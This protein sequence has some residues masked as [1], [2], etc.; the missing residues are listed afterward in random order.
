MGYTHVVRVLRAA[1][2]AVVAAALPM[3]YACTIV[4]RLSLPPADAGPDASDAGDAGEAAPDAFDGC[5][6]ARFPPRPRIPD[7]DAT[8]E[9][10]VAVRSI[11]VDG[12]TI[13]YDLD[14][15][16]T[17]APHDPTCTSQISTCDGDGGVDDQAGLAMVKLGL[18][19]PF[20]AQMNDAIIGAGR[21]GVVI[22]VEKYNGKSEDANVKVSIYSSQGPATVTD[23]GVVHHPPDFDQVDTWTVDKSRLTSNQPPGTYDATTEAFVTGGMLVTPFVGLVRMSSTVELATT[24]AYLVAPIDL[25]DPS[26]PMIHGGMI[27]GRWPTDKVLALIEGTMCSVPPSVARDAICGAADIMSEEGQ[28]KKG[29]PCN[30]LSLGL[31]FEAIPAAFGPPEDFGKPTLPCLDGGPVLL[32]PQ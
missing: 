28:D 6:H 8:L 16:C 13:G 24:G 18:A 1:G 10:L 2:V 23:A 32:C 20:E 21:G 3:A 22:H 14:N 5:E 7:D 4:N 9:I 12:G 17:C 31:S 29:L 25:A 15:A 19:E 11:H 26:K 27:A 30:A